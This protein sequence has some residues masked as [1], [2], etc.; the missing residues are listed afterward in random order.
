MTEN[1]VVEVIAGRMGWRVISEL[2][3]RWR[4]QEPNGAI[5]PSITSKEV[6]L[7]RIIELNETLLHS[8]D[9]LA[10]VLVKL[11]DREW[12]LLASSIVPF[13]SARGIARRLLMMDPRTLA[14]AVAQAIKEA[15]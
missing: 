6:A 10:P 7:D 3:K 2:G 5:R 4:I 14:F 13:G 9:A 11:T 12:E 1:E 15:K 8:R